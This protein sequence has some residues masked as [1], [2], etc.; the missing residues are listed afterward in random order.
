MTSPVE[1]PAGVTFTSPRMAAK[2]M[3]VWLNQL[4]E[5]PPVFQQPALS[6][7]DDVAPELGNLSEMLRSAQVAKLTSLMGEDTIAK[8]DQDEDGS[9]SQDELVAGGGTEEEFWRLDANGDKKLDQADIKAPSPIPSLG[10]RSTYRGPGNET[11]E[12]SCSFGSLKVPYGAKLQDAVGAEFGGASPTSGL[13]SN[14]P[15][16]FPWNKVGKPGAPDLGYKLVCNRFGYGLGWLVEELV[17]SPQGSD[18]LFEPFQFHSLSHP[19]SFDG[20]FSTFVLFP[21]FNIGLCMSNNLLDADYTEKVP[22]GK[23][24][25]VRKFVELVMAKQMELQKERARI[26]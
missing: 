1:D 25:V 9:V 13:Q 8:Y 21:K 20:M 10:Q 14:P 15:A 18:A 22:G 12:S 23:F 5:K 3:K 24:E 2:Y 11:E 6:L 7:Q 26:K 16:P 4:C 19:G 17:V